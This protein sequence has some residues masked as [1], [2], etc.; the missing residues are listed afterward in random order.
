MK[1]HRKKIK[2]VGI[3]ANLKKSVAPPIIDR[4]IRLIE[5]SGRSVLANKDAAEAFGLTIPTADTVAELARTT[6]LLLVFGGDGTMLR[7]ARELHGADI[8]ILGINLGGL[9]FLTDVPSTELESALEQIWDGDFEIES[10]AL[11]QASTDEND[12]TTRVSALN[13][14]VISRGTISRLIELE[15]KVDGE[16]LTRYRGDGLIVSTPTGSTAYSLAA[17]GAVVFPT[18]S[19][20]VITPICPHTLTNRSVVVSLHSRIDVTVLTQKPETILSADG[21]GA[22]RLATGDVVRIR[23]SRH[24]VRLVHLKGSSFFETLRRKLRW[25][26]SNIDPK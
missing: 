21:Q 16:L 7:V 14:I 19:V 25:S 4:A 9:G 17:G 13:D 10:R 22:R 12:R 8:P 23:Q 15:V 2:R 26:G 24:D 18:A 11:L 20:F 5:K 1:K 6:D 3:V